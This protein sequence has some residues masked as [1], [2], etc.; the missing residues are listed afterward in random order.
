MF[1]LSGLANHLRDR[2]F[3][4]SLLTDF[5]DMIGALLAVTAE[6]AILSPRRAY[7]FPARRRGEILVS[8]R[9]IERAM[10]RA[11]TL[12]SLFAPVANRNRHPDH[13]GDCEQ[14]EDAWLG[15]LNSAA[16]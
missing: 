13:A 15:K 1:G 10:P 12:V 9:R 2:S 7:S 8:R 4:G 5:A 3:E 6:R 14:F 11:G 16:R